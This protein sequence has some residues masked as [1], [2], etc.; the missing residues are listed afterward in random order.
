MNQPASGFVVERG[1]PPPKPRQ[2]HPWQ[3]FHELC[4]MP[5]N[6]CAKTSDVYNARHVYQFANR[7]GIKVTVRKLKKGGWRI[8]RVK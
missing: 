7:A 1:I 3:F 4:R 8:W 2:S 6:T 5:V